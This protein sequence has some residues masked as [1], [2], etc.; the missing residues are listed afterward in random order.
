MTTQQIQR[1]RFHAIESDIG[2]PTRPDLLSKMFSRDQLQRI[3]QAIG[4]DE[5]TRLSQ[6]TDRS[7]VNEGKNLQTVREAIN[8]VTG[9]KAPWIIGFASEFAV[10]LKSVLSGQ[11]E[12]FDLSKESL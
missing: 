1:G 7:T 10:G 4:E 5:L 3:A 11:G 9:H 6:D 8:S 2:V 12:A